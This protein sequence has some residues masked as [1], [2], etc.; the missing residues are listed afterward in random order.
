VLVSERVDTRICKIGYGLKSLG[1]KTILLHRRALP[2]NPRK[3]FD[4][5]RRFETPAEA[6]LLATEYRPAVYHVFANWNYNVA[7]L[8]VRHKPGKI[9]FDDYDVLVGTLH[10]NLTRAY[11]REIRLERI[12]LEGAD[13]HCCRDLETRCAKRAG[14]RMPGKRVLLYDCCWGNHAPANVSRAQPEA[15]FHVVNCGNVPI[16]TERDWSV[17]KEELAG[18]ARRLLADG[19][20]APSIHFHIYTTS[21]VWPGA[22]REGAAEKATVDRVPVFVQLHD[23]VRPDELPATLQRYDAGLYDVTVGANPPTYNHWKFA[24]TSG[25][26]VF[27]YLDA[28]LPVIVH[29]CKFMEFVVHRARADIR[30]GAHLTAEA[31]Q[32]LRREDTGGLRRRAIAGSASLAIARHIPKL[33]ALYESLS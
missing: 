10:D 21:D 25:N 7:T 19:L 8:F 27:D 11:W 4:E 3:C 6:L 16:A 20:T 14:Y 23:R 26:R 30:S 17:H 22:A 1:W 2:A 5:W 18:V 33:V 32:F 15:G 28:G 31:G 9:V 12:C 13:G 29:G 24:Y